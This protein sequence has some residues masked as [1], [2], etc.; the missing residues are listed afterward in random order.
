[1][2]P[3]S[4]EARLRIEA[5]FSNEERDAVAKL[6]VEEC[7]DR[8]PLTDRAASGFWDRIR[9]AVLKLSEGDL[10][11]LKQEIDGAK[12]DWRDTLVAAGFGDSVTAHE[13][14]FPVAR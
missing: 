10:E 6:L 8:L 11:R 4:V 12:R 9:F 3:L 13:S 1:M 2:V 14:W 7:G 5:L